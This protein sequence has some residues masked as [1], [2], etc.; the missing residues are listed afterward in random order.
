MVTDGS[1][2]GF[3]GSAGFNGIVAALFG[4][5]HPIWTIPASFLF[6]GLL[7]G[8]L[9][10]GFAGGDREVARV[11]FTPSLLGDYVVT[12]AHLSREQPLEFFGRDPAYDP[13]EIN[14]AA[15]PDVEPGVDSDGW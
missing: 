8:G 3:T 12:P 9:A 10:Y 13:R 15:G 14:V 7:V 6:G 1:T 11:V 5:L 4:G 2:A